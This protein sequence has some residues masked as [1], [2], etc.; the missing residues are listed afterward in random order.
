MPATAPVAAAIA[1]ALSIVAKLSAGGA[2]GS[3]MAV[4]VWRTEASAEVAAQHNAVQ[5]VSMRMMCACAQ[6][7]Q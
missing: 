7:A 2:V 3:F 4:R 5:P 1:A 6:R